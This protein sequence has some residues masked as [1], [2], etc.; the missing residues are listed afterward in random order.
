MKINFSLATMLMSICM[1]TNFYGQKPKE[2]VK[3][4]KVYYEPGMFGGWPANHG[5]W[6]LSLI[7]I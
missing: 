6:N 5:V 3:H 2:N 7:H 1:T 4:V